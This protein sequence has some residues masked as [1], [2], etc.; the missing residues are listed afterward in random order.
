MLNLALFLM[1]V[2]LN[3]QYILG[4]EDII[5]KSQVNKI[6]HDAIKFLYSEKLDFYYS[7]ILHNLDDS[8]ILKEIAYKLEEKMGSYEKGSIV[9]SDRNKIIRIYEPYIPLRIQINPKDTLEKLENEIINYRV[10]LPHTLYI[11]QSEK[12][13]L[14]SRK[15]HYAV[16]IDWA[17]KVRDKELLESS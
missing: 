8:A 11:I 13:I 10:Q 15:G 7:V 1:S 2:D 6:I 3:I 16:D 9:C 17:L 12:K 4:I 5:E 14:D